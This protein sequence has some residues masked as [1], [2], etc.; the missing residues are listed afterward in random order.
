VRNLQIRN[1]AGGDA[2][3]DLRCRMNLVFVDAPCTGS[4]TWRRHPDSKWRLTP[5]QLEARIA[6]QDAILKESAAYVKPGGRLVY[7]TCSIFMEENED[8]LAAFRSARPDFKPIDAIDEISASTVLAAGG[9]AQ[10]EPCCAAGGA[11][12]LTPARV[13]T[14]GFFIAALLRT[15]LVTASHGE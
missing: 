11:L 9:R 15:T 5:Q 10:L 7:V 4:G 6:E 8:R 1:P 12:R 2:L 3:D 14:D 13:R